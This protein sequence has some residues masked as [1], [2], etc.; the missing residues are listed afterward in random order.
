MREAPF[1]DRTCP[2]CTMPQAEELNFDEHEYGFDEFD[3]VDDGGD[4][5]LNVP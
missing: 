5:L 3:G 1:P 4:S 2:V